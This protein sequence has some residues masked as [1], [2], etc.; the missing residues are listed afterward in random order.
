MIGCLIGRSSGQFRADN[1]RSF[2]RLLLW[3]FC[4]YYRSHNPL[5]VCAPYIVISYRIDDVDISSDHILVSGSRS[6]IRYISFIAHF[7]PKF[8]L[9]FVMLILQSCEI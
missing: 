7:E 8:D 5:E 9:T 3:F 1:D 4:S 2:D 6:T